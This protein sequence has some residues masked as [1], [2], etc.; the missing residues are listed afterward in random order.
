[1]SPARTRHQ[2]PLSPRIRVVGDPI[3]TRRCQRVGKI[4]D[5]ARRVIADLKAT[6]L[7]VGGAGLSAPQIGSNLCIIGIRT[8]AVAKVIINPEIV[9][10]SGE[11][12]VATERGL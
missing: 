6:L 3:L 2:H 7:E 4:N 5:L 12:L 9:G 8:G 11:R 10:I 1:M